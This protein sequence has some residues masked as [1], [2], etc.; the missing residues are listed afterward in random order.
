[1]FE[2]DVYI[3]SNVL[4]SLKSIFEICKSIFE[5]PSCAFSHVLAYY[6]SNLTLWLACSVWY[7]LFYNSILVG[8]HLPKANPRFMLPLR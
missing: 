3:C 1:M 7:N 6:Q 4:S 5:I 2:P 8:A